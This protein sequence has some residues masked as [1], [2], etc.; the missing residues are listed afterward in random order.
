ML[1]KNTCKKCLCDHYGV[2]KKNQATELT[3][4]LTPIAEFEQDWLSGFVCCH[5]DG[6]IVDK[7]QGSP[8]E[9]CLHLFEHAVANGCE[10]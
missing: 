1:D 3:P 10:V 7:I 6:G 9:G 2:I 8:P 4:I 5:L